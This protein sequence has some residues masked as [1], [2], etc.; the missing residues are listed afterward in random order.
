MNEVHAGSSSSRDAHDSFDEVEERPEPVNILLV[1]DRAEDLLALSTVLDVSGYRLIQARSGTEALRVL[2]RDEFAV[3]LL[4]INMPEMDGFE[5]ASLIRQRERTRLTPIVFMSADGDDMARVYRAYSVGAIDC[6]LK[7][8]DVDVVRAKVAVFADLHRKELRLRRQA[9][10]L[11]ESERRERAVQIATLELAAARRYVNLAEA[12]PHAVFTAT[13]YGSVDYTN[14]H[15]VEYTG[16]PV[17]QAR[18]EGWLGALHPD[19]AERC[20]RA[21]LEAMKKAEPFTVECRLRR[22]SDGVYRFHVCRVVPERDLGGNVLAWLGTLTDFEELKQ[23]IAV[24]DE[25]MVIASHELRTP[26]TALKLRLQS[27]QRA[28]PETIDLKDKLDGALRQTTRLERLIDN[29]LDVSRVATGHLDIEPEDLDLSDIVRDVVARFTAEATRAGIRIEYD[30]PGR[31]RGRW[32]R[33]RIEQV[34]TNL[35]SNALRYGEAPLVRIALEVDEERATLLVEGG[36]H[37]PEAKLARIFN[38]FERAGGPRAAGGLGVGLYVTRQ[39]VEAHGGT[40]SVSSHRG[41]PTTFT[42]VL[43]RIT[44]SPPGS[45]PVSAAPSSDGVA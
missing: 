34:L 1:D 27:L 43:P 24:R 5:F 4:D 38:R 20:R 45:A 41:E 29:L 9:L 30:L 39:I 23:A 8:I 3:I 14:R 13:P 6:L 2:L 15:W 37:I 35:L 33:L 10:A 21:L 42:V 40:I 11:R 18:G 16:M 25:F 12:I 7:P 28:R 17:A 26:L 22:A 44:A 19:D 31:S 32:D 36:A